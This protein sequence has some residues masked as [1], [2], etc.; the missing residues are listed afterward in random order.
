MTAALV[1]GAPVAP[2][3]T[4]RRQEWMWTAAAIVV[5]IALWQL[6]GSWLDRYAIPSPSEI[7]RQIWRDREAYPDNIAAT[8]TIGGRGWLVGNVLATAL[9]GA[10]I[11]IP[12]LERPITRFGIA[13]YTVPVLA[14]GPI[15]TA[16]VSRV[17]MIATL[18]ALAVF[19][20]TMVGAILGLKSADPR[21]L[22]L[23]RA[24][25]GSS[26]M[27]LTKVRLRAAMPAYF[28]ALRIS[29]PAAAL[30]TMVAEWFSPEEGLGAYMVN[31]MATSFE[32][33]VWGVAVV[34]TAVASAGY[35]LI[36]LAGW[37][38]TRWDT[39]RGGHR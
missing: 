9:A 19:F 14:I 23:I 30:G 38:L 21:S 15:L 6:G 22:D 13:T 16:T 37:S 28:A 36:S 31:A 24:L 10:A 39:S 3:E 5:L 27:A 29:A 20:T 25:G 17:S 7:G 35:A 4:A 34:A 12:Q 1:P 8:V 26:F 2:T 32:E 18:A 33:R 11:A